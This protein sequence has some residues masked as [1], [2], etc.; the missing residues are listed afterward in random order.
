MK[1]RLRSPHV[2]APK[3]VPDALSL[4]AAHPDAVVYAGGTWMLSGLS[5]RFPDLPRLIVSLTNVEELRR[6]SRTERYLE[7]GSMLT[8]AQLL[9][10]GRN[11][12][13]SA[14]TT[15]IEGI[16]NPGVRNLATVGGN[17]CVPDRRMT[18]FPVLHVMDARLE[19]RSTG[20]S[21]WVSIG[22]FIG[23]DGR[24]M[25]EP[26]EILVR[27]RLPLDQWNVQSFQPADRHGVLD[28]SPVVFCGL[29]AT[30]RDLITDFR[31]ICCFPGT[32]YI[33]SRDLEAELV[34]RKIPLGPKGL[35]SFLEDFRELLAVREE[36][37]SRFQRE[38]SVF[39]LERF[40]SSLDGE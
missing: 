25:I 24:P 37:F 13:P 34:G 40:L 32:E 27:I 9:S 4:R 16:G 29:A 10:I 22:R 35:R 39:M 20:S 38:Q 6:I 11:V 8:L 14:L 31:A 26:N 15:A 1:T 12:L 5:G 33:R 36:R 28:D 19:L 30:Q 23:T 2:Y 3:T 21:R 17:L 18:L 7:I